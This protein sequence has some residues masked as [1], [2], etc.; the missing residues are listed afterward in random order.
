MH[1]QPRMPRVV[2]KVGTAIAAAALTFAALGGSALAAPP[3]VRDHTETV[4]P[5]AVNNVCVGAVCTATSVFVIVDSSGV[6]SRAC[7]DITR[8]E[9]TGPMGF[10]PLGFE[11][12][13]VSPVADRDFSIDTKSLATAGLSQIGIPVQS[14]TCV[15]T[16][17]SPTGTRTAQVSAIYTGVGDLST[18]RAN[19]KSTFGGCTMYFVGKGISRDATATLTVDGQ[20]LGALGSLFASTRKIKILCH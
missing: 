11:T 5:A 7:L 15:A 4:G 14:F 9:A 20:S 16:G 8:F 12:G 13:C 2:R 19:S 10:V 6:P 18:F 17:C 1:V 3:A